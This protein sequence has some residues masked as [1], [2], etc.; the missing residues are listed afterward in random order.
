MT[1]PKEGPRRQ[2]AYELLH[3]F[4]QMLVYVDERKIKGPYGETYLVLSSNKISI[5]QLKSE[6]GFDDELIEFLKTKVKV[7]E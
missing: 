2:K 3:A 1:K 5:S 4:C 6:F 7:I